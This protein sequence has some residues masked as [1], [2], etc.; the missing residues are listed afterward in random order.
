MRI[1]NKKGVY[2]LSGRVDEYADFDAFKDAPSPLKLNLG[3]VTSINS[4][5]VRKFLAFTL[6]WAPRT[7][8]FYECTPEFIANINVIPQM[9]GSPPDSSQVKSFYVP[10][11]CDTCKRVENLLLDRNDVKIEGKDVIVPPKHCAKCGNSLDLE[12]ERHE[13]LAFLA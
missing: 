2:H 5:G 11:S 4:I 8:E 12:V 3:K 9:L 6:K 1:D 13:Y 7:F 10:F